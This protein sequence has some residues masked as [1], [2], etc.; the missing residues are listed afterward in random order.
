VKGTVHIQV[1][2]SDAKV[3]SP[4]EAKEIIKDLP[5]TWRAWDKEEKCWLV[6]L[7]AVDSLSNSLRAAGF[8]VRTTHDAGARHHSSAPPPRAERNPDTWAD[9]MYKALGKDLA[10][11]AYKALLPV[12]HPDRGGAT[13]PMQQL[14][15]A[16]DKAKLQPTR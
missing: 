9:S 10:D 7:F 5:R 12:L 3:H 16:R 11:K 2:R 13:V 6:Q 8:T 4:F 14:N 15:A 1:G